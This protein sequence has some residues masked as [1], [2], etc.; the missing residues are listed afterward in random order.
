M[1]SVD[2]DD[3]LFG[4]QPLKVIN[5][6]YQDPKVWAG[7]SVFIYYDKINNELSRGN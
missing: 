5:A 2:A 7:N 3:A 6:V 4:T 1:I